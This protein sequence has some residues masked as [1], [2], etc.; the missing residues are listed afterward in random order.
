ML[1]LYHLTAK[2]LFLH[3]LPKVDMISDEIKCLLEL[4]IRNTLAGVL[5]IY[6]FIAISC[7][8]NIMKNYNVII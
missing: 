6:L 5:F 3:A 7:Q 8:C 1:E 4:L 2:S